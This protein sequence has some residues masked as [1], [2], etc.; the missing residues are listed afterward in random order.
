MVVKGYVSALSP[1]FV[2][3]ATPLPFSLM[4]FPMIFPPHS[5]VTLPVGTSE[6]VVVTVA[7]N[8][9]FCP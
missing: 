4:L 5:K 1:D 7:V 3:V 9:T 6:P 8:V 2:S